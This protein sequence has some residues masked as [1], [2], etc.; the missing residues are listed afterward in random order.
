MDYQITKAGAMLNWDG[1]SIQSAQCGLDVPSKGSRG[2]GD[3]L[4][5]P[6]LV[7]SPVG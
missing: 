4:S 5:N 2:Q 3:A 1:P 6:E 7:P